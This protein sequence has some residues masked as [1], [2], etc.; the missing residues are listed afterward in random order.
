MVIRI[1]LVTNHSTCM[2][3]GEEGGG[4]GGDVVVNTCMESC[5]VISG[6][7]GTLAIIITCIHYVIDSMHT[8]SHVPR[9]PGKVWGRDL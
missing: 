7:T 4:G 9:L 1:P 2:G 8:P 6:S 5:S 3:P